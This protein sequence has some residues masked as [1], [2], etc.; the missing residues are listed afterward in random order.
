MTYFTLHKASIINMTINQLA[1]WMIIHGIVSKILR[2]ERQEDEVYSFEVSLF[3]NAEILK[4]KH[5]FTVPLYKN[6]TE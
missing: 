2:R 3:L 5:I 1:S 6:L 4:R